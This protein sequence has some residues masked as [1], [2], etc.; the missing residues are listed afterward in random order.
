MNWS[1]YTADRTTHLKIVVV[2]LSSALLIDVIGISARQYNLGVDI[3]SAQ[4]PGVNTPGKALSCW[5]GRIPAGPGPARPFAAAGRQ[6]LRPGLSG[7]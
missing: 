2:G 1:M 4:G 5:P 7:H 6:R 3:M